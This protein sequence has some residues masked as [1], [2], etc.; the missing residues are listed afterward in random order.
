MFDRQKVNQ[1]GIIRNEKLRVNE[2]GD[3]IA[4]VQTIVGLKECRMVQDVRAQSSTDPTAGA[5]TGSKEDA[6]LFVLLTLLSNRLPT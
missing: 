5:A 2:C 3:G 4:Y 6:S 1:R